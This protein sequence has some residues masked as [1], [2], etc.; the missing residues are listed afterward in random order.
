MKVLSNV[1]ISRRVVRAK[2]A[3]MPYS[4][5]HKDH[6]GVRIRDFDIHFHEYVTILV[7]GKRKREQQRSLGFS[8]MTTAKQRRLPGIM[9]ER[10]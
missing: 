7:Q 8:V 1:D 10:F 3:L 5:L 9:V 6:F 2:T 4:W